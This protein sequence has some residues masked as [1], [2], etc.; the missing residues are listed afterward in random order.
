[1]TKAE[2]KDIV[3]NCRKEKKVCRVFLRYDVNYRYYFPLLV[4]DK[5]F[6]GAE[7]DDFLIDGYAIRRFRDVTKAQIKNDLCATI[8][9]REGIADSLELPDVDITNWEMVFKSLQK[10]NK[11]VIVEKESLN[12]D[13]SEFVIG[14][15][16]KVCKHFAYI[17]HFDA[18]GVWQAE[19]Y[20][21]PY[22][23]ITSVTYAS[24][25]IETFS[26]YLGPLPE[27]FGKSTYL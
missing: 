1:M 26:K 22:T 20:K 23:G 11:N 15:I 16:E 3:E 19:S 13:D 12:A 7:E 2:I 8:L 4:N 9:N 5:L 21:I 27:N 17:R 14:K 18:D 25:Y 24:R 6:L 10:I